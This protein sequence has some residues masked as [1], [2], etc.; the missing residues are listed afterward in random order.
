L[1]LAVV[2]RV[3]VVESVLVNRLLVRQTHMEVVQLHKRHRVPWEETRHGQISC[4]GSKEVEI[5][6]RSIILPLALA[7]ALI[8][9]PHRTDLKSFA[10]TK[11]RHTEAM[12]TVRLQDPRRSAR[13][14]SNISINASE[15]VMRAVAMEALRQGVN[16]YRMLAHAWKETLMGS[17]AIN[18]QT[19]TQA[20]TN[21]L[22]YNWVD[23]KRP[24]IP[25]R[26]P[27]DRALPYEEAVY[28]QKV[29]EANQE[30]DISGGT[31][32]V[33]NLQKRFGEEKSLERYRGAG[34]GARMYRNE[35]KELIPYL[36]NHP[37]VQRIVEGE[38]SKL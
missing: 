3:K 9:T 18:N 25:I 38:R 30:Q 35:M 24:D 5:E 23:V 16:P 37:D 26:E 28:R 11:R 7:V 34:P 33:K 12:G 29:R 4:A 8:S 22:Q 10:D 13:E 6:L 14:R 32:F 19:P 2:A 20:Y 36:W 17:R 31:R 27:S 15:G 21:P 1:E